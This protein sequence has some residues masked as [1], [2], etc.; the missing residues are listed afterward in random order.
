MIKCSGV[1][2]LTEEVSVKIY[3]GPIG[4]MVSG[5]VDSA[6]LLYYL[7]KHS[8]DT[9]HIY[10]TGSNIKYRRNSIIAPRVVEKC[11]QLTNNNNVVHHIH[12]DEEATDSSMC[13]APQKDI[14][15]SI[16]KIRVVYDGTTMNPP[17]DV[18]SKFVPEFDFDTSR[19]NTGDNVMY[20]HDDKFYMPWANIDKQGI[21][22]MYREEKLIDS[23]LPVTRSC[24]YDPTSDYYYANTWPRWGDEIRD[25]YLGH[26]GECWWCKE[27]EWGFK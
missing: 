16:N 22:K 17:D 18:A 4:I 7:M 20:Y 13:I 11:I 3:D 12:Y 21:A 10:T 19:K 27:R 5:G 25:P 9:I 14:R 2:L 23:L 24:E 26:C 1:I 15:P 6:I 8:K